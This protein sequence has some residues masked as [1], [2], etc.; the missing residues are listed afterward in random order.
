MKLKTIIFLS[1]CPVFS[2][3]TGCEENKPVQIGNETSTEYGYAVSSPLFTV[4]LPDSINIPLL[5]EE[6]FALSVLSISDKSIV[7]EGDTIVFGVDPFFTLEKER[8]KMFLDI[9]EASND[10]ASIDS[11]RYLLEDSSAYFS[12][13]S[14]TSGLIECKV[15]PD[16]TIQPGDTLALITTAPPDSFYLLIPDFEQVTNAF[17]VP[18][19]IPTQRGLSF[20]GVP[21]TGKVGLPQIWEVKSNFIYEDNLNSFL[22]GALEDTIPVTIIGFTDST[23]VLFTLVSLDSIPLVLW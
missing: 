14:T 12:I 13:L 21:P 5:W 16:E 18:G 10:F 15:F 8:I 4:E 7:F 22:L 2:L 11:L 9:A 1:V 23:R 6:N 3:L 19:A 17:T 20:I